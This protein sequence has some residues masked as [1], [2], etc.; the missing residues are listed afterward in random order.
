M[1][2]IM[3]SVGVCTCTC[4]FMCACMFRYIAHMNKYATTS[5]LDHIDVIITYG[6][7]V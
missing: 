6:S 3:Y 1:Q 5:I 4:T 2:Y 7:T